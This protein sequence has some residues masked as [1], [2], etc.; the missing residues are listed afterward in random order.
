[1]SSDSLGEFPRR[2]FVNDGFTRLNEEKILLR[3]I[4][5]VI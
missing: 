5:K 4:R 2:L 3:K 1:M